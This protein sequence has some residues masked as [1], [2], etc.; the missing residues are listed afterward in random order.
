MRA[1]KQKNTALYFFSTVSGY[2]SSSEKS[3]HAYLKGIVL[4]QWYVLLIDQ[5]VL[6]L[7]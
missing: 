4:H 6:G 5:R 7:K 3:K 1:W 2:Q